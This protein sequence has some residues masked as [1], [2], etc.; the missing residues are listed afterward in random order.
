M[1]RSL[2]EILKPVLFHD[3]EGRTCKEF[4]GGC[5]TLGTDFLQK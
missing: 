5:W 3:H 2:Y 4:M 1:Y